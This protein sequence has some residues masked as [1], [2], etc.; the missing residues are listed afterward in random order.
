MLSEAIIYILFW[1]EHWRHWLSH[2][3]ISP[4]WQPSREISLNSYYQEKPLL[5]LSNWT[6]FCFKNDNSKFQTDHSSIMSCL[7]LGISKPNLCLYLTNMQNY[8]VWISILIKGFIFLYYPYFSVA[9]TFIFSFLLTLW[10]YLYKVSQM[11]FGWKHG[12]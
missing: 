3:I 9:L 8:I 10:Y 12:L 7:L 1:G 5:I 2:C 6:V 11:L 4:L